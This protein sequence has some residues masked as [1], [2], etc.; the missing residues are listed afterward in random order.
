MR[1]LLFGKDGQAGRHLNNKLL[2]LGEVIAFGPDDLDLRDIPRLTQ[3]IKKLQPQIVVNAAAYT[4]VDQAESE[5]DLAMQVNCTAPGAMAEAVRSIEAVLF[6]FSTDYVFDGKKGMPYREDDKTFPINVYGQSKLAGEQAIQQIDCV[7][8]I[9]RT[10]WVYDLRG[11]NF[12]VKMLSRSRQDETLRVVTDQVGSPTWV[13][14]LADIV[15]RIVSSSGTNPAE[16]FYHYRGIYHLAGRGV[17]SRYD[18]AREILKLD[19]TQQEQ[20]TRNLLPALSDEFPSPARRPAFSALDCDR[21]QAVFK[22][23]L[24]DWKFYLGECF[25][26]QLSSQRGKPK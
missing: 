20:K 7:H 10:S 22:L 17:A 16:Y 23:T 3:T 6:H 1:I 19:P 18:W 25:G 26:Q 8:V 5:P 21:I 12:L 14:M 24:Q 15:A 11:D 4:A 9:L 13:G 2:P